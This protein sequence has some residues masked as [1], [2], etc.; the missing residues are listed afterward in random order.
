MTSGLRLERR[1]FAR[2]RTCLDTLCVS[3]R[4]SYP[5]VIRNLSV[6]GAFVESS[7]PLSI[8]TKLR[9]GLPLPDE[10]K[11]MD[12]IDGR[13]A[14]VVDG[15]P[16]DLSPGQLAGTGVELFATPEQRERLTQLLQRPSSLPATRK[17][18]QPRTP[19][20]PSIRPGVCSDEARLRLD[21]LRPGQTR[22]VRLRLVAIG[23]E[24]KTP[25]DFFLDVK[26][27]CPSCGDGWDAC[28][29]ADFGERIPGA[30]AVTVLKDRYETGSALPLVEAGRCL[31][32]EFRLP[33]DPG[34]EKIVFWVATDG[35]R[36]VPEQMACAIRMESSAE[37]P[38]G[39]E[40]DTMRLPSV[41]AVLSQHLSEVLQQ[42]PD[43][44]LVVL[45]ELMAN[46]TLAG[47]LVLLRWLVETN[48]D[49]RLIE[50][51][52]RDLE[53]WERVA[54]DFDR[55]DFGKLQVHD[56]TD[57]SLAAF[58]AHSAP[59]LL[60][61]TLV[62]SYKKHVA[63]DH[64]DESAF[65]GRLTHVVAVALGRRDRPA[66]DD[67]V[68]VARSE[69]DAAAFSRLETLVEGALRAGKATPVEA[70]T[71]IGDYMLDIRGRGSRKPLDAAVEFMAAVGF[72]A[73]TADIE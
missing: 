68:R 34:V 25:T 65:W 19:S 15:G 22:S 27:V 61:T 63:A 48:A 47:K 66:L 7:A 23:R 57:A 54:K 14:R 11:R 50:A 26:V 17:P 9:L 3:S 51:G 30:A 33:L 29:K 46:T 21:Q 12:W 36:G 31:E 40:L 69:L 72:I 6:V 39:D 32:Q 73:L 62:S 49:V 1:R 35:L 43:P 45:G 38:P 2:R 13:V 70:S 52:V 20:R 59:R 41:K 64:P 28:A 18:A 42:S 58:H 60:A 37:E 5:G 56:R 8:G 4:G 16:G 24:G 71:V 67:A 10:S 53:L 44:A 55:V